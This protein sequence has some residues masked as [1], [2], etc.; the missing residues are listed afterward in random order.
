M[1]GAG[2]GRAGRIECV[3]GDP[4]GKA[5]WARQWR[6][7]LALPASVA[8]RSAGVGSRRALGTGL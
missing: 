7:T 6:G 8:G 2:T 3:G 5:G 1:R 4:G